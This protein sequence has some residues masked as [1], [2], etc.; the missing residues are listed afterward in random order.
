MT[1]LS[2]TKTYKNI[3]TNLFKNIAMLWGLTKFSYRKTKEIK[4]KKSGIS[5]DSYLFKNIY[6]I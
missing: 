2:F 6:I 4:N 3:Q 5:W 1:K